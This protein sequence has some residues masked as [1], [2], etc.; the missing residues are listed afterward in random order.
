MQAEVISLSIPLNC[1][2]VLATRLMIAS[3]GNI[4][5][6]LVPFAFESLEPG[7]F[8][9][10]A[11]FLAQPIPIDDS[12]FSRR[13]LGSAFSPS[14]SLSFTAQD[15]APDVAFRAGS[16][17]FVSLGFCVMHARSPC[18]G[19]NNPCKDDSCKCC[20]ATPRRSILH[21]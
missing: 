4:L 1:H 17:N 8:S 5:R 11:G 7:L 13:F 12:T 18:L 10:V 2:R 14:Q 6:W 9:S 19:Q 20:D 3:A 15:R 16:R 21:T